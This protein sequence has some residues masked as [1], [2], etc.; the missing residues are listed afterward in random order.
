MTARR[1]GALDLA[2]NTNT[3]LMSSAN[4]FDSTVNI[5]FVNRN[6]T[7]IRVRLALVDA[8]AVSA[9][10]DLSNSDYLEFDTEILP[11]EVLENTG[12]VVPENYSL[13]VRSDSASVSVVAYGFEEQVA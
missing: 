8:P 2:A 4:N 7:S 3:V 13:V 5:R 6:A 12:I 9:L 1:F 11:N 10:V